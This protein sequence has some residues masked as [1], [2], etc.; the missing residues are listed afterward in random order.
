MI[1]LKQ[2]AFIR[3][4]KFTAEFATVR[5]AL[6]HWHKLEPHDRDHA[7]LSLADGKVLQPHEVAELKL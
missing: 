4:P 1:K 3:L 2:R 7:V 6:E 5:E